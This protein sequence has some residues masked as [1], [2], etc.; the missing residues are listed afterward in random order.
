MLCDS[1]FLDY[2]PP[3]SVR[4]ERRRV[5]AEVEG[6]AM[7]RDLSFDFGPDGAYAQD[8]RFLKISEQ[9]HGR[10]STPP[11]RERRRVYALSLL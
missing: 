4:P 2:S 3:R 6:C 9:S 11:K 5:S 8:E 1:L 7:I 10:G